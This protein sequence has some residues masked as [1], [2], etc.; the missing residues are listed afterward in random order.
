MAAWRANRPDTTGRG[1]ARHRLRI[2]PEHLCDLTGGEQPLGGFHEVARYFTRLMATR[3][4]LALLVKAVA[5]H[6]T[7]GECV[8]DG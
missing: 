8:D 1:P 6:S 7:R 3:K 5:A 2:D 4:D